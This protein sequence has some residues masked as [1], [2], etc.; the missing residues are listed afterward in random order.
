[1]CI[2]IHDLFE[3]YTLISAIIYMNLNNNNNNETH[4][5]SLKSKRKKNDLNTGILF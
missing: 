3:K 1:M 4:R 2:K 5:K